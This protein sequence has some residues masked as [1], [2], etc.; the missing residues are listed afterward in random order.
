MASTS[1]VFR[2]TV[3]SLV[4]CGMAQAADVPAALPG[5]QPFPAALRQQ[6]TQALQAKPKDYEPR[7]RHR[8]ADGSPVYSNRLLF[9]PS[10][11]L[12]QH[13]HN[14]VDWRPW[15]DA[16]FDAARRLGRPVLVS[17]GY[18][19]CHW[20]HV[21]EEESFD[22]LE[23]AKLLNAR[24]ITIKVDRELRP[25]ID[26]VYMS[27]IHAMGQN[28]GWPLNVWVTADRKPFYAGTYFPAVAQ[29]R[30]PSFRSVL[31]RIAE[32]YS[33]DP[34]RVSGIAA[35]VTDAVRRDLE[36]VRAKSSMSPD[37]G[38]LRAAFLAY[39]TRFD[40]EWGGLRRNHK[41][42]S[43]LPIRFLLRFHRRTG[44]SKALE[45]AV[46]TL[47]KMAAGGIHDQLA[48][49]FHRYS[50]DPRWL[51]PH[52]EKMLYDNAL[53]VPEYLEAWQVTGRKDFADVAHS[54]L[55][56]V[57]SE[58]TS[59]GGAFYSATDADSVTPSG[60]FEEGWYFSWSE[61]EIDAALSPVEAAVAK[62]VWGVT[63]AGNFE[64]RNVLHRWST[65]KQ[66]AAISGVKPGE[67][68]TILARARRKLLE[69]RA[70]RQA[71]LRDDKILTSWNGLM[72][73]AFA[74]AGFAFNR[75]DYTAKAARAAN[76]LLATVLR[77]GRL[78]H[79]IQGGRASGPAFLEDYAFLIA[80]LLDLYEAESDLN[81]LIRARSLQAVLD[82]D[83]ADDAGGGYFHTSDE[84][85][86]LLARE[87]PDLDG[88]VP[89][90]N[91]VAASNLLRLAE[92]TLVD[93]YRE[94]LQ[95]LFSA[96]NERLGSN[97]TAVP[98]LLL[99][100]DFEL[101]AAKEIIVV[102]PE[103]GGASKELAGLI[104][105]LRIRF[106]PNRTVSI[107]TEGDA[108]S[109]QLPQLPLLAGKK[110]RRG[111]PTAYVCENRVCLLPTSDRKVF[112]Q[113]IL[114]VTPLE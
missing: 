71:P 43:S 65:P 24:F 9:E 87:K 81:W 84:H 100:L 32:M 72:I 73:S 85:E 29:G 33:N 13:A 51:V 112:E 50:V 96:F 2:A 82:A 15:G 88:A 58:M 8:K 47:E 78:L 79:A 64:G 106:V 5:A 90:G 45:M 18:S 103:G 30:R 94:R 77:D 31:E 101:D 25:D 70:T 48:G 75:A 95:M 16:A 21:M 26:A 62:A 105:P 59:P 12:Q 4:V 39:E 111:L 37:A 38:P 83:Y 27:A 114:E 91:S 66:V 34:K 41:F 44:D 55:A 61:D 35:R 20:C 57:A 107:V 7:T 68:E 108:L 80:G 53:R 3:A 63:T 6:L 54:T 98:E 23:T 22:N 1:S 102:A 110:S 93:A 97:P 74:R 11:Y 14:P 67:Q 60:E 52:F 86:R 92:L 10:P 69:V 113:Q 17:I 99:A 40:A 89:S 46:L 19:T 76:F 28:G 109:A 56:Y 104:G 42:P 49:G 36:G